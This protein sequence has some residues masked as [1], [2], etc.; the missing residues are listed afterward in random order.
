VGGGANNDFN[1]TV[2]MLL[3]FAVLNIRLSVIMILI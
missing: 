2:A 3:F 1:F